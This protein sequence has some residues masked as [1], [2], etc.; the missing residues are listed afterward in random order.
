M[1]MG[2]GG[3]QDGGLGVG[4]RLVGC[5]DVGL[6]RLGVKDGEFGVGFGVFGDRA[7]VGQGWGGLGIRVGVLGDRSWGICGLRGAGIFG[8]TKL[9]GFGLGAE[10]TGNK[11]Q[12]TWG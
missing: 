9:G 5:G 2:L 8:G 6:K 3:W 12:R 11:G 4:L 7:L 10:G 1:G